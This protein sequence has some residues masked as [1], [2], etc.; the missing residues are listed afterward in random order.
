MKPWRHFPGIHKLLFIDYWNASW[1]AV[2]E[3]SLFEVS[4]M[5]RV[6]RAATKIG[7]CHALQQIVFMLEF[8]T[9]EHEYLLK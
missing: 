5:L 1:K 2:C 6:A 3:I 8:Y 7:L 4:V 9:M